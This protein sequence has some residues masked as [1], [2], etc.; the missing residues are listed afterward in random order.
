MLIVDDEPALR[1]LMA[2][3][4]EDAG[5]A[6]DQAGNGAEALERLRRVT[7]DVIVLDLLMPI[8]GGREVVSALR[9]H[10]ALAAI[11]VVLLSAA[12]DLPEATQELQPR[13][14]LVKPIDLDVLVAVVDR[15][16]AT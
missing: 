9:S 2:S 14:A 4:L 6:V 7:P 16:A 15:V 8:M 3:Y 13:A 5:Y 11:P 10:P 12:G 1:E